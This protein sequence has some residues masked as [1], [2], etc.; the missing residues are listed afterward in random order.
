MERV[1]IIDTNVLVHANNQQELRHK[2]CVNL[3]MKLLASDKF[4]GLDPG[5]SIDGGINKS[6][7]G[8][9]YHKHLIY[10]SLGFSLLVEYFKNKRVKEIELSTDPAV[11]KKIMTRIRNKRDRTFL[12]V[13]YNSPKKILISHDFEDFSA[14]NRKYFKKELSIN[15][16]EAS[17]YLKQNYA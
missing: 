3:I 4:I 7:I 12:K 10:G 15:I 1:I 2:Y 6:L 8:S 11:S 13:T 17:Q 9:E 16:V 14:T 5:F